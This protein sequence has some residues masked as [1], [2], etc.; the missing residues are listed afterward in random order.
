MSADIARKVLANR[1]L[2][3][4]SP[5]LF[6]DPFDV[7]RELSFG[8]TPEELVR[9]S[10]RRMAQL[11][12]SPPDDTRKYQPK[13]KMILEAIKRGISLDV[14]EKLL[15]GVEEVVAS[16][17]PT[18]SNM[19]AL[20]ELWRSW[21]PD[22]R[23]LCLTESPSHAA[24]WYHYADEY[25]GVVLEFRCVDDLDSPWLGARP[26]TY[27][28]SK[29]AVYTSDGWAELLCLQPEAA[30]EAMLDAAT[31]TKAPDWSY[32]AEWRISSFK[33]A[34]ETGLFTNYQFSREELAGVYFG[35]MIS[36][37]DRLALRIAAGAYPLAR[38]RDIAIGMSREFTF[39][40]TDA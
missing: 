15:A 34:G 40:D 37:D 20:R 2:R 31:Y 30:I 3:W 14:K 23:I 25:R 27:P 26:V 21:L 13:L 38:L 4:S 11:I 10:G 29:P 6:N 12:E 39:R 28:L 33:R 19:D 35:P 16:N 18:S 36:A 1:T 32:E 17:R 8:I 24:M 7:P 9:A 22:H 5:L